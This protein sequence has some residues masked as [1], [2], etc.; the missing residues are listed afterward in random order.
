MLSNQ[1]IASRDGRLWVANCRRHSEY[2]PL[3]GTLREKFMSET[4]AQTCENF[5]E[6]QKTHSILCVA[7]H[8]T[9]VYCKISA[10]MKQLL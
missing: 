4:L 6:N 7:S 8:R 9:M 5:S 2:L 3:L 1:G 10:D